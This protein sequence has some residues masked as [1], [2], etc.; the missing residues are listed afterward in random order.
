MIPYLVG[1]Y[2]WDEAWGEDYATTTFFGS[3]EAA[4]DFFEQR[5]I[6]LNPR[7]SELQK[8]ALVSA[9]EQC[10]EDS[11]TWIPF[12]S[13][14][15]ALAYWQCLQRVVPGYINDPAI[16]SVLDI[17][18]QG[19]EEVVEPPDSIPSQLEDVVSGEQEIKLPWWLYA[20]GA[21]LLIKVL[22]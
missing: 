10:F 19:S 17:A 16:F 4:K 1:A 12:D 5:V 20:A 9:S 22:K 14:S 8:S 21:L 13:E 15:E 6:A 18:V 3:A 7:L 11:K 2:Y